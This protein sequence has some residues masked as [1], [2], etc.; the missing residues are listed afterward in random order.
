M[1]T[2]YVAPAPVN[3]SDR[4]WPSRVITKSPIWTSVDLRDGNQALPNPMN[5]TQKLKYFQMLCDIGFKEIEIGFPS[6]SQE[7]FDF[8]QKLAEEGIVPE[9][10]T[11]MVLTQCR[12]HLIART[13][14]AIRGAKRVI[15]HAYCATSELHMTR[16][17]KMTRES[18]L[19]MIVLAIRQIRALAKEMP[20]TDVRLEFSPE[21][22]TDSEFEFALQACEA[23]FE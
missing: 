2:K 11:I 16:V 10:A 13:F 1:T 21:E 6:A 7:D 5:P 23:G 15:F 12:P 19:E 8:T 4:K 9:D 20:E 14:E 22:F 3:L 17:F 18:T